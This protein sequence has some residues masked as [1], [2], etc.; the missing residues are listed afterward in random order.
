MDSWTDACI[1]K[2][3]SKRV[4]L[5]FLWQTTSV[6][7]HILHIMGSNFCNMNLHQ[8]LWYEKHKN[9]RAHL[10]IFPMIPIFTFLKIGFLFS[11]SHSTK[12]FSLVSGLYPCFLFNNIKNI[13]IAV[14]IIFEMFYKTIVFT[15]KSF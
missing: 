9:T 4:I 8:F 1:T 7:E 11:P 12:Y 10:I 3:G 13:F 14:E 2:S 6:P 15:L 5:E